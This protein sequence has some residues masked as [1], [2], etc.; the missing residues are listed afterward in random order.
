[1]RIS[2]KILAKIVKNINLH[3]KFITN[4]LIH[5][6]YEG[7]SGGCLKLNFTV[8]NRIDGIVHEI[9]G[10]CP[11]QTVCSAGCLEL[12]LCIMRWCGSMLPHHPIIHNDVIL[13]I[14]L[15]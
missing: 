2:L 1:M 3:C 4:E 15:T 14:V 9:S 12:L 5:Y 10:N 7:I 8:A 13:P 6:R 11:P